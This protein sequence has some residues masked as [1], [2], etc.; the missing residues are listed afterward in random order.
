MRRSGLAMINLG[1]LGQTETLSE[2][3]RGAEIRSV[4]NALKIFSVDSKIFL[5][6]NAVVALDKTCAMHHNVEVTFRLIC[7]SALWRQ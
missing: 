1:T 7:V 5:G 6:S 2:D 4:V 3:N